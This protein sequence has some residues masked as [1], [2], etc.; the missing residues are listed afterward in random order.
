MSIITCRGPQGEKGYQ[1]SNPEGQD[2]P[3]HTLDPDVPI[4]QARAAALRAAMRDANQ[5]A[6]ATPDNPDGDPRMARDG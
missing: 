2:G 6:S 1:F 4:G 5:A 3:C